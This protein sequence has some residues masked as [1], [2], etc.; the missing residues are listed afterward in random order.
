MDMRAAET[1]QSTDSFQYYIFG[2]ILGDVPPKDRA[3]NLRQHFD[4]VRNLG[5]Y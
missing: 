3:A 5:D 1:L 4:S 2:G